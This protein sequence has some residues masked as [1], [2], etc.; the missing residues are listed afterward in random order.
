MFSP[1]HIR[2]SKWN[3][4]LD[5]RGGLTTTGQSTSPGGDSSGHSLT[6]PHSEAKV[7]QGEL[8]LP[9]RCEPWLNRDL[10]LALPRVT[11][12]N[13]RKLNQKYLHDDR[14]LDSAPADH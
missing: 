10:I 14:D 6:G 9:T 8:K 1:R 12:E 3:R 11:E 2:V 5:E 4:H 7:I 13:Q